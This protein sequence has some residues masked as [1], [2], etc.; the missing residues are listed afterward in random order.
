MALS[1]AI[2][3]DITAYPGPPAPCPTAR[4]VSR[5]AA[6][7]SISC[8]FAG[9][10]A[11]R[12][13]GAC[14]LRAAASARCPGTRPLGKAALCERR[15]RSPRPET[16]PC[17]RPAFAFCMAS[18]SIAVH[19][20][21][22][23]KDKEGGSRRTKGRVEAG[24]DGAGRSGRRCMPLHSRRQLQPR[25][26]QKAS[27]FLE[28]LPLSQSSPRVRPPCPTQNH[29]ES[30]TRRRKRVHESR[31]SGFSATDPR[32]RP[33]FLPSGKCRRPPCSRPSP[34]LQA[35]FRW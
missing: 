23:S 28:E 35:R 27:L 2:R 21:E 5:R 12:A 32:Q 31:W 14:E 11:L 25:Q 26:R 10:G 16:Y 7:P 29:A 33:S 1:A 30:Q 15:L 6:C 34:N 19:V 8:M 13:C 4:F 20:R 22:E 24:R 17:A 18:N 3:S 9:L